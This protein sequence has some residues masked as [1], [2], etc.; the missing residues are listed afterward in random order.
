MPMKPISQF[1]YSRRLKLHFGDWGNTGKP[2]LILVHGGMDHDRSWDEI[3]E[4]GMY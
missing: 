3:A 1:Y 4:A 2:N